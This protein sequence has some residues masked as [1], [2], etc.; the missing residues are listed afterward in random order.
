MKRLCLVA[1]MLL[2][3]LASGG[4]V[5]ADE[6]SP[7][8][9]RPSL[10]ILPLKE[11][12]RKDLGDVSETMN[13]LVTNA[14][15]E[16]GAFRL[17]ER[18]QVPADPA[19]SPAT[20]DRSAITA[21]GHRLGASFLLTGYYLPE[22]SLAKGSVTLTLSLALLDARDGTVFKNL[23]ETATGP[24]LGSVVVALTRQ[25]SARAAQAA[26]PRPAEAAVAAA[27]AK[28]AE[29]VAAAQPVH[30]PA[31]AMAAMPAAVAVAPP[32]A[33]A[34]PAPS[35]PPVAAPVP[36]PS[37]PPAVVA[38]AASPAV[39][40]PG[41]RK[42]P[43]ALLVLREGKINGV[44]FQKGGLKHFGAKLEDFDFLVKSL[45]KLFPA[46]VAVSFDTGSHGSV[47]DAELNRALVAKAQPDILVVVGLECRSR[48]EE[49][50]LLLA[51]TQVQAEVQVDFLAPDTRQVLDAR[52]V[53]TDF[54]Q[55]KGKG[56]G[57]AL[58]VELKDQLAS[59]ITL[60]IPT[61]PY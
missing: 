18:S 11:E 22:Y 52:T 51:K 5:A 30:Q 12:G 7:A 61:L 60:E 14:F 28:G 3:G 43:R 29:A 13:M 35:V 10:A 48:T 34:V 58:P 24:S 4:R 55:A 37:A 2:I 20:A 25:V 21:L 9:V 19:Q 23:Q 27:P 16:S 50:V 49:H 1:L 36:A 59:R 39:A 57:L 31:P 26:P 44:Y 33:A 53:R 56:T 47:D 8:A 15:A 6:P 32:V 42:A 41:P 17:L 40:A 45:A 54:L 46:G 38:V